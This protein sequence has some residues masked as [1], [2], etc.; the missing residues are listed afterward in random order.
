MRA[1]AEMRSQSGPA[2]ETVQRGMKNW[3]ENM[4]NKESTLDDVFLEELVTWI[5]Y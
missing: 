3:V 2:R 5:R 4:R 1:A